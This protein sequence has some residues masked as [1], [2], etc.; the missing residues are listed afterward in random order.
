M[1]QIT[2]LLRG[3]SMCNVIHKDKGYFP[4]YKHPYTTQETVL[5]W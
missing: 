2:S 1:R 3:G 4:D 5:P